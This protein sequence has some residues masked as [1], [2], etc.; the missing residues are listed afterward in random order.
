MCNSPTSTLEAKQW[1]M[2]AQLVAAMHVRGPIAVHGGLSNLVEAIRI[3]GMVLVISVSDTRPEQLKVL[4]AKLKALLFRE[5][6]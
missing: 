4:G 5:S 2:A 3:V 6:A 1:E